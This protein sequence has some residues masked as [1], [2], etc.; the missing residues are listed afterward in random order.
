METLELD[1]VGTKRS[2]TRRTLQR[3]IDGRTQLV[4]FLTTVEK[5][6]DIRG[7]LMTILTW[8]TIMVDY[9]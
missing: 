1:W 3:I 2:R 8:S 9:R 5:P 4:K 7:R 6:K